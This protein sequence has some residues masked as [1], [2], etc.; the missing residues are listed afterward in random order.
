MYLTINRHKKAQ[1]VLEYVVL[2]AIAIIA[3]I[4]VGGLAK[5]LRDGSGGPGDI[6]PFD[7][8]FQKMAGPAGGLNGAP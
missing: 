4:A 8:H 2:V 6:G 3:I 7:I 1:I 5:K